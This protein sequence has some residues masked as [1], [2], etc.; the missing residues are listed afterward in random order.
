MAPIF[1]KNNI[2][3]VKPTLQQI[4][5]DLHHIGI[6]NFCFVTGRTKRSIEDHFTPDLSITDNTMKNFHEMLMNSSIMWVNQ[7]EPKGFGH[8]V[9]VSKPFVE[10]DDFIVQAGDSFIIP[11]KEHPIHKLIEISKNSDVEA[12]FLIRKVP[13]PKRHGIVTVKQQ[14]DHFKVL[15]A[16]EKSENP[17]SSWGIMPVYYFRKSILDELQTITPGINNEIQLTDAIQ[18]LIENGKNV[19]AIEINHDTVIDVGTPESYWESIVK[20]YK[21][22]E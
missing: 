16:I 9:L 12:A 20:S 18:K 7:L 1:T 2:L 13:D 8:A 5:E 21:I 6:R 14:N 4:F 19:V 10:N 22:G 3:E 11:K 15:K 17:E